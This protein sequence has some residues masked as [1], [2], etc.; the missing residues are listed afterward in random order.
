MESLPL[1]LGSFSQT[2]LSVFPKMI[3]GR[4]VQ[5]LGVLESCLRFISLGHPDMVPE[6]G[7]VK[8]SLHETLRKQLFKAGCCKNSGS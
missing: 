1:G 5:P 3:L 8:G 4:E 7:R 2:L 6:V